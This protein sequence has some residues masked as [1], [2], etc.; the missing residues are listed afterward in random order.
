MSVTGEEAKSVVGTPVL[1]TPPAEL[2]PS[3][4]CSSSPLSG[5]CMGT[6]APERSSGSGFG[7]YAGGVTRRCGRILLHS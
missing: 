3:G 1:G 2:A 5:S 4:D 7:F 6:E